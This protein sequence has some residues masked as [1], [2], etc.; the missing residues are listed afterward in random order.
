M[1]SVEKKLLLAML[2]FGAVACGKYPPRVKLGGDAVDLSAI[3]TTVTPPGGVYN[4]RPRIAIVKDSDDGV[5]LV[6]TPG[7]DRFFL[8]MTEGYPCAVPDLDLPKEERREF[9]CVDMETSGDLEYYVG[10]E[11]LANQDAS[12]VRR[13]HYEIQLES[14]PFHAGGH[15]FREKETTC[16]LLE[17]DDAG[18]PRFQVSIELTAPQALNEWSSVFFE[19]A[20]AGPTA[21]GKIKTGGASPRDATGGLSLR[22]SHQDLN[23]WLY[24]TAQTDGVC[25]ITFDA[26]RV[27]GE[28]R[29]QVE[30]K[31][32]KERRYHDAPGPLGE[33]ADVAASWTCDIHH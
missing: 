9:A 25:E 11:F 20:V 19:F 13:E 16:R 7:K 5:L 2:A 17:V 8:S 23:D 12:E 29:G 4:F 21:G 15:K 28:A 32:L 3:G 14:P 31:G 1:S 27:N 33:V 24:D 18:L 6:R 26:W 22:T 10:R 30:C